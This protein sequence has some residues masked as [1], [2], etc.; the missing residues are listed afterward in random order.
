[1]DGR[2]A[3]FNS[4]VTVLLEGIGLIA[5]LIAILL[6]LVQSTHQEIQK[7]FISTVR[8]LLSGL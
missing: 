2:D 6:I 7:P 8:N 1:M 5:N 3:P 4:F